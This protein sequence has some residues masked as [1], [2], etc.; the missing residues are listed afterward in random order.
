MP[1]ARHRPGGGDQAPGQYRDP[2]PFRRSRSRPL[3]HDGARALRNPRGD[4]AIFRRRTAGV[5]THPRSASRW[6]RAARLSGDR[7]P[8]SRSGHGIQDDWHRRLARARAPPARCLSRRDLPR[9]GAEASTCRGRRDVGQ[10]LRD[11]SLGGLRRSS[12]SRM[13]TRRSRLRPAS[14]PGC[15]RGAPFMPRSADDIRP[16]PFLAEG[17]RTS[18]LR[19]AALTPMSVRDV[20]PMSATTIRPA[21]VSGRRA[22]LLSAANVTASR[23]NRPAPH[24]TV[25]RHS[26]GMS[27][28]TTGIRRRQLPDH[29]LLLRL[30]YP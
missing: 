10:V 5:R 1:T 3:G 26:R 15:I 2:N 25:S 8:P 23:A 4:H 16:I 21:E 19:S 18:P 9:P 29:S 13:H 7:R 12:K 27:T 30:A 20:D 14:R 6:S 11:Y 24:L 28:A 17:Q 22:A